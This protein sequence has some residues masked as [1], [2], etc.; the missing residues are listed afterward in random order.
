V[1][2][3]RRT[4]ADAALETEPAHRGAR[5]RR[6]R[7][8]EIPAGGDVVEPAVGLH[9]AGQAPVEGQR[10]EERP[11]LVEV[12]LVELQPQPSHAKPPCR[13]DHRHQA[14]LDA[15]GTVHQH[16]VPQVVGGARARF[17]LGYGRRVARHVGQVGR[18]EAHVGQR[19][20]RCAGAH[21]EQQG[22]LGERD[23][24][25]RRRDGVRQPHARQP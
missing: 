24:P 6:V 16:E 4:G 22:A 7:E 9:R 14:A 10:V 12:H 17:P 21:V 5:H 23:R 1:E 13:I 8:G 2:R 15:F 11:H 19:Q 18:D 25:L 3:E 20:L